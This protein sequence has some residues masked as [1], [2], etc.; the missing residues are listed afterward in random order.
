MANQK[1]RI[2]VIRT[3]RIGDVVVSTPVFETLKTAYPD[4]WIAAM[5]RPYTRD[6]LKNNPYVD[7]II[8][9][10]PDSTHKG[11]SGILAMVRTLK[12]GHFDTVITLFSNFRLGLITYMAGIPTRIAP[13]TKVAQLFYNHR[14]SQRRS[15]ST[16]HEA[17]YNLDLLKVL[18]ITDMK[19]NVAIWIDKSAEEASR[20]YLK[21]NNLFQAWENKKLIGIH[22]GSGGSARNWQPERYAQLA[23]RLISEFS[24]SVLLT[25]G[26]GEKE[27]LSTVQSK[28]TRKSLI[29]TSNSIMELAAML[30][31]FSAF[32]SS[33]TGPMHMAAAVKTP[34]VSL[35]CPITACL[36]IR[37][38]PIGNEQRVLLPEAPECSKCV[39]DKCKYFDCMEMISIDTTIKAV[40]EL[41]G[42]E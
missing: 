31:N 34:T 21:E 10:K 33:S 18:G 16:Q 15:K 22:P 27:L 25:G 5:V 40:N 9:Y 26:L 29:F 28:M 39:E 24:Y 3:D 8:E 13:A 41:V 32:I 14:I 12:N 23:D 11:L 4:A 19:K 36:P 37:W 20:Q 42:I 17:D 2:L 38:G 1:K 35:F 6:L 7:E 30:K